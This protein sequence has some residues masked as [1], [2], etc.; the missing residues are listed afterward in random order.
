MTPLDFDGSIPQFCAKVD[1]DRFANEAR[2]DYQNEKRG[3]SGIDTE[4]QVERKGSNEKQG[5]RDVITDHFEKFHKFGTDDNSNNGTE[6]RRLNSS[7]E[8]QQT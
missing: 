3:C 2:N 4:G 7:S 5:Q 8:R 6:D 1:S